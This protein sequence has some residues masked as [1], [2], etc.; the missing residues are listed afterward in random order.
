M[1]VMILF[2][3]GDTLTFAVIDSRLHKRKKDEAVLE[4][5]TL[6]KGH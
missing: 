1:P 4:K 5:A 3:H 2:Q 6:I